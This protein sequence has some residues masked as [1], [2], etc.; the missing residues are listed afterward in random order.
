MMNC[1]FSLRTSLLFLY[2][3]CSTLFAIAQP[4]V[5]FRGAWIATVDNID[6]PSQGN[7]DSDDQKAEFISLL[8]MHQRNGLNAV[9]VQIR[10]CTDAFYPSPFEPWS[11]WLTGKQGIAPEPYYDPLEFMIDEA[12][13]R[14]LSFHAWL[15][16]Y[17]AEWNI[18][19]NAVAPNHITRLY[20]GWFVAY[21]GKRYFD[22]G[23]KEAQDYVV[24]V[25]KDIVKRYKVD[26]IHMDDYFYPYPIPR[27]QFPDSKSFQLYG[28]G[29]KRD[30]W[31]RSNTD[32]IIAKIHRVIKTEKKSCAFGIS[33]FGVWRN[34]DR[35]RIN[36]SRTN[37]ALSNYDDLYADILKWMKKDWI[38]YVA[39]Q[40]YWEIGHRI[41]DFNVLIDWW[42]R[43]TYGKDCYIGLAIYRAGN[44]SAW[45]DKTQIPRQ[46]QAIRKKANLNGIVFYSSKSFETN[47]N[48]WCDSLRN[49]YFKDP[50]LAPTL[51]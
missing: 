18:S 8:D 15:N 23:N 7:F 50:A 38:D 4:K 10:P 32:S 1:K 17:R 5:E 22:P 44:N 34:I 36:G 21:G 45:R 27:L 20:P 9:I 51:K 35:D 48:G 3:L 25:V 30:D 13:K 40:L 31:R 41:A 6:W 49:N 16:P 14:G 43:N 12:H 37:G 29:L 2:Y 11:E 28:K 46:I 42:D 39:P 26:G 24:N 33:P 19:A 47:P